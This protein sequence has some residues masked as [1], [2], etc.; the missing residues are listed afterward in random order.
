MDTYVDKSNSPVP[1]LKDEEAQVAESHTR[2]H[3]QISDPSH[4]HGSD[5][6]A[7]REVT[8][9]NEDEGLAEES[10]KKETLESNPG[11]TGR[12]TKEAGEEAPPSKECNSELNQKAPGNCM[13][14]AFSEESNPPNFT[15]EEEET[16]V[17]VEEKTTAERSTKEDTA[18]TSRTEDL[19]AGTEHAE[20]DA[21]AH[22]KES[23]CLH[24]NLKKIRILSEERSKAHTSKRDGR[25]QHPPPTKE[26]LRQALMFGKAFQSFSI[27]H[28]IFQ[29]VSV[30]GTNV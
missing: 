3:V 1:I 11:T 4:L 22:G 7:R 2:S 26:R 6:T 25:S 24:L 13:R 12:E 14:A 16:E 30:I 10:P 5:Q 28:T 19:D 21:F 29:T 23:A 8:K 27:L 18:E 20:D 15:P 17:E 9:T